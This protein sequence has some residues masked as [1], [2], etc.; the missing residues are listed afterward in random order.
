MKIAFFSPYQGIWK[1]AQIEKQLSRILRSEKNSIEFLRCAR[2]YQPSCI[3]F[4]SYGIKYDDLLSEKNEICKKC[5]SNGDISISEYSQIELSDLLKE[6]D[7]E[8]INS[9]VKNLHKNDWLDFEFDS[10]PIGRIAA[11]EMFTAK[12]FHEKKMPEN[13][14]PEYISKVKNALITKI[15][16]D[17]YVKSRQP[18][19]VLAY[20]A[21]YSSNN[22]VR[23]I[24]ENKNIDFFGIHASSDIRKMYERIVLT[25]DLQAS[26]ARNES[27]EWKF[28][29]KL[30]LTIFQK[31]IVN[32]HLNH[33]K[34]AKSFWTYSLPIS[35]VTPVE[36]RNRLKI[37]P[38]RVVLLLT[39][40]SAN[41]NMGLDLIGMYQPNSNEK[42]LFNSKLEMVEFLANTVAENPNY[43]LIIRLHP[44]EFPNK[45]EGLKSDFALKFEEFSKRWKDFDGITVNLPSDNISL[46][47]LAK[48]VNVVLNE[49]SSA[50]LELLLHKIPLITFSNPYFATYPRELGKR[51]FNKYDILSAIEHS[52]NSPVSKSE[53]EMARKWIY[54]INRDISLSIYSP[55][56][57]FYFFIFNYLRKLHLFFPVVT[58][59]IAF[60][61]EFFFDLFFVKTNSQ[62]AI[63]NI[64]TS[65]TI[66]Q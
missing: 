30:P 43:H 58:N 42:M 21:L 34:R 3:V 39:M 64:V 45:R 26:L 27:I 49:E 40:S 38:N 28:F 60:L 10:L 20:N 57:K 56:D 2:I 55:I 14:W 29:E 35:G 11:Y 12:K 63:Y 31:L 36:L 18:D 61:L 33:I 17:N 54:F 37:D 6:S 65:E 44:R 1:H 48:I 22:V 23:L 16:F 9:C 53:L 62:K 47:D 13:L 19:V 15:S 24:C 25:K 41:E 8:L 66:Q 4:T 46:Y 52:S 5:I 51:V 32:R 7:K 50:G 59:R